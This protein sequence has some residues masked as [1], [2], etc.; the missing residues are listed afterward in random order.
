MNKGTKTGNGP[1]I[2]SVVNVQADVVATDVPGGIRYELK[3]GNSQ[4]EQYVTGPTTINIPPGSELYKIHFHIDDG[5]CSYNLKF[6]S[7]TPI[8][9]ADGDC[10]PQSGGIRSNQLDRPDPVRDRLLVIDNYNSAQGK[11]GFAL[12]FK[13]RNS[14]DRIEP[15]DPIIDNGG[16]GVPKA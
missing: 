3:P 6:D 4:S 13:D 12:L 14:N 15:F 8:R 2:R 1:A 9:A 10:C 5:D 16:G 7:Q 11:V